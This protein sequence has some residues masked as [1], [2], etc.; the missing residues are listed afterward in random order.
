MSSL[1]ILNLIS[2]FGGFLTSSIIDTS[3]GEFNEWAI[4]GAALVIATIEGFN[5]IY[6]YFFRQI[7]A[8]IL[9][10]FYF[11]SLLNLLNFFKI[12]LIY[13]LIVDAFKLGS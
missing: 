1:L 12:G 11:T 6:Y 4:V 3:L 7:R 2:F 8:N 10:K 9:E 13:G 5:K